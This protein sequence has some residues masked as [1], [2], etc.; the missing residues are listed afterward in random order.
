MLPDI[1]VR[2]I[3]SN[4]TPKRGL[5]P[6][7]Q[8]T[9]AIN[10]I[11]PIIV[12]WANDFL[13]DIAISGSYAKNTAIIGSTDLDL[14]IS[15]KANTPNTLKEVHDSLDKRL[16]GHGY[17]TRPQNVSIGITQNGLKIDLVPGIKQSILTSDHTIYKRKKDSWTK[18]NIDKHINLVKNSG[19]IEEIRALKIWRELRSLDFL[20]F[21]LELT[22]IEALKGYAFNNPANNTWAVLNYLA[23]KFEN[24]RV[25]DPSNTNNI[26]SDELTVA[27]KQTI[28]RSAK[29]SLQQKDWSGIIW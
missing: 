14:F 17:N 1:Y 11:K 19:R 25:V 26:L 16:K 5:I 7:P 27:E 21:Y 15:L 24:A 18:T 6:V 13:S 29:I 3:I 4:K 2:Q 28:A 20:S 22:V 12:A 10:T 8:I 23:T 9:I